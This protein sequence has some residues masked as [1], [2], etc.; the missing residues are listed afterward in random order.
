MDENHD[1]NVNNWKNSWK[2]NWKGNYQSTDDGYQFYGYERDDDGLKG[3]QK[4]QRDLESQDPEKQKEALG[5]ILSA[6]VVI[7][8]IAIM[9]IDSIDISKFFDEVREWIGN[10]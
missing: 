8:I 1:K 4:M 3:L 9:L 7:V 2:D 10:R 5:V 6:I